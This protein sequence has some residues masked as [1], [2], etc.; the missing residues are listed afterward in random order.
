VLIL[1]FLTLAGPVPSK[2]DAQS[3][4]KE[5]ALQV[6]YRE[7]I[8]ELLELLSTLKGLEP[9]A[10]PA[11]AVR[12]ERL[13]DRFW[14]EDSYRAVFCKSFLLQTRSQPLQQV[15]LRYL[16]DRKIA[17]AFSRTLARRYASRPASILQDGEPYPRY[18]YNDEL[19]DENINF[20]LLQETP[21]FGGELAVYLPVNPYRAL[22]D[23]SLADDP[24]AALDPLI[25]VYGGP[26]NFMRVALSRKAGVPLAEFLQTIRSLG[27]RGI[28][29][30]SDLV[31][32][33][34]D[35]PYSL[36][37][38]DRIVIGTS[39]SRDAKPGLD[40]GTTRAYV[41]TTD[42][43]AYEL[44][45]TMGISGGSNNYEIRNYLWKILGF[46]AFASF[47]TK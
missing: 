6:P 33:T 1:A 29:G 10:L 44:E 27:K 21:V 34:Y 31:D 17:D 19:F 12:V 16:A 40:L 7:D 23:E 32:V 9:V 20:A 13:L 22:T 37:H 38:V 4:W 24:P 36:R 5:F 46:C 35:S 11:D 26:T 25:L 14:K 45:F 47:V 28:S 39:I 3:A 43:R 18:S 15:V 42:S 41:H 30:P 2:A 8:T